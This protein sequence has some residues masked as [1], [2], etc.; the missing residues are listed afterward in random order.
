MQAVKKQY[1]GLQREIVSKSKAAQLKELRA[2][3]TLQLE[4]AEYGR[5]EKVCAVAS[6]LWPC[7]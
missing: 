4:G 6:L 5:C 2:A 3:R 7:R 1:E